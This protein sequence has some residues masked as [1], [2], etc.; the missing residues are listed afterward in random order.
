[1]AKPTG[2]T[3]RTSTSVMG[4]HRG[5]CKSKAATQSVFFDP[6]QLGNPKAKPMSDLAR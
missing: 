2:I 4:F 1:M 6:N 5:V 3:S